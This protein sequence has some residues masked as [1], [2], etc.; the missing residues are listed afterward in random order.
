MASSEPVG[1]QGASGDSWGIKR[2]AETGS[3]L[4]AEF[5]GQGIGTRMRIMFLALYFDHLDANYVTSAAFQDNPASN[6]VSQKVGYEPD[7]LLHD[8]RAGKPALL[9]RWRMSRD[10][11]AQV[12]QRDLDM[13]GAELVVEGAEPVARQATQQ[14]A[15][16]HGLPD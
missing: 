6:A 9:N 14:R 8:V 7:G 13:L 11:W 5:H 16:A 15:E 1:I 12:R 2:E 4:G 10:R 3:W